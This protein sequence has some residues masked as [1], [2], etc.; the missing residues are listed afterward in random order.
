MLIVLVSLLFSESLSMLEAK[1]KDIGFTEKE[2]KFYMELLR[3]GPQVVSVIAKRIGVNRTTAYSVLN[4]LEKKGVISSYE[5]SGTKQFV[6]NDPN[7]LIVYVDRRC[8]AFDY[9]RDEILN[10]VPKYRSLN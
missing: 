7:T 10:L 9:Y 6:A 5:K 1:L 3:I 4:S 2:A 8:R